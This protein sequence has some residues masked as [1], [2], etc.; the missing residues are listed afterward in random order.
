MEL[1]QDGL[2]LLESEVQQLRGKAI[3]PHCFRVFHCLH[4]C[5]NL[6]LRGLDPEGTRDWVLR[7]PRRDVGIKH[8]G[9]GVQQRAEEP[10]PIS[11]GFALCR[12]AVCPPHHGCTVIRPSLS[13]PPVPI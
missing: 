3:R 13:P 11:R 5:G 10:H 4:H 12:A 8:V 9:F 6:L 7:Q 1:Q 2:V